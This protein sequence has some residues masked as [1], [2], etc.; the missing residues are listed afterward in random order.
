MNDVQKEVLVFAQAS[1][2]CEVDGGGTRIITEF[3]EIEW[4]GAAC[5]WVEA[6]GGDEPETASTLPGALAL[7]GLA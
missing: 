3:G 7:L 2:D 6:D 4:D 1:A 5:V